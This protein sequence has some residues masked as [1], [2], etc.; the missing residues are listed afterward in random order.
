MGC[1]LQDGMPNLLDLR[2]ADDILLFPQTQAQAALIMDDIVAAL[3]EA[4]F[5]L[6]C[7]NTKVLTTEAQAAHTLTT[8]N[9]LTLDVLG[10]AT[11]HKWLG[12]LLAA[13]SH[14]SH[15]EDVGYHVQAAFRAFFAH[16]WILCDKHAVVTPIACFAAG[17]RK[18]YT[19][20]LH[21]RDVAMR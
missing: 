15:A 12:C 10:R 4:G 3:A 14:G 17:H 13:S 6:N 2:F 5:I 9:G 11:T 20:D 1:D 18:V 21:E 16:R 19:H 8:R 7:A